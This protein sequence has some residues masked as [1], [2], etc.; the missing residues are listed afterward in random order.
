MRRPREGVQGANSTKRAATFSRRATRVT[1]SWIATRCESGTTAIETSKGCWRASA[2]AKGPWGHLGGLRSWRRLREL[3]PPGQPPRVGRG[4]CRHIGRKGSLRES[5]R[6]G[7]ALR[8][9]HT[10]CL[11]GVCALS[12]EM[13][14]NEKPYG[15]QNIPYYTLNVNYSTAPGVA[16]IHL[17]RNETGY[18]MKSCT[19]NI[20]LWAPK[21]S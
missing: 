18:L 8:G 10:G 14:N 5:P 9:F 21:K 12:W 1:S 7:M 19:A 6:P 16:S 17:L 2:R 20:A 11:T 13:H 4:S 3:L 15:Q